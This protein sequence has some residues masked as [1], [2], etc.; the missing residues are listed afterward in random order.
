MSNTIFILGCIGL[1][2]AFNGS[3]NLLIGALVVAV[4]TDLLS[5]MGIKVWYKGENK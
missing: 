4:L 3:V 5:A 2:V 1:A